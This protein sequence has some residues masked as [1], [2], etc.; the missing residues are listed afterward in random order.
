MEKS[1]KGGFTKEESLRRIGLFLEP[2]FIFRYCTRVQLM[3]IGKEVLGFLSVRWMIDYC[4]KKGYL[5]VHSD[6]DFGV[7]SLYLTPVGQA[8][9]KQRSQIGADWPVEKRDKLILRGRFDKRYANMINFRH[10]NLLVGGYLSL[11]KQF[12][13]KTCISDWMLRANKFRVKIIPDSLVE[14]DGLK[15][16]VEAEALPRRLE[17]W[18]TTIKKYHEYIGAG[19][20]QGVLIIAANSIIYETIRNRIFFAYPFYRNFSMKAIIITTLDMLKEGKCFYHNQIFS[21]GVVDKERLAKVKEV[22][23]NGKKYKVL[24]LQKIQREKSVQEIWTYDGILRFI[25]KEQDEEDKKE[26]VMVL[27][28][29]VQISE[30]FRILK[31][32]KHEDEE[33]G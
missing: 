19:N 11:A 13:I 1:R 25:D 16:A 21:R 26:A 24:N 23:N 8:L 3:D 32:I 9:I 27:G 5:R 7:K 28:N 6:V 22:V 4:V 33:I 2:V 29:E 15:I 20:V 18:K 10:H 17:R 14:F 30:A 12:E 31:E